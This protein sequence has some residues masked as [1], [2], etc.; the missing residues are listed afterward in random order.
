MF[1]SAFQES[2]HQFWVDVLN[3]MLEIIALEIMLLVPSVMRNLVRLDS[4]LV[5]E[6]QNARVVPQGYTSLGQMYPAPVQ[7]VQMVNSLHL[8]RVLQTL[9]AAQ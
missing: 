2:I 3:V 7:P 8:Q 4:I 1:R 9:R 6:L 5:R